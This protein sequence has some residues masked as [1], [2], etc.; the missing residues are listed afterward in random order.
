MR[1]RYIENEDK[2]YGAIDLSVIEISTRIPVMIDRAFDLYKTFSP[3]VLT[4]L[5]KKISDNGGRIL[6]RLQSQINENNNEGRKISTYSTY[7]LKQA[8]NKFSFLSITALVDNNIY[9]D[10]IKKINDFN[11]LNENFRA[12]SDYSPIDPEYNQTEGGELMQHSNYL[13]SLNDV[14]EKYDDYKL[15]RIVFGRIPTVRYSDYYSENSEYMKNGNLPTIGVYNKKN[16]VLLKT[17]FKPEI[18]FTL[19]D[20]FFKE[21]TINSSIDSNKKRIKNG[22]KYMIEDQNRSN[23]M[24]LDVETLF[25]GLINIIHEK[26]ISTRDCKEFSKDELKWFEENIL[27]GEKFISDDLALDKIVA[28]T[29]MGEVSRLLKIIF[30]KNFINIKENIPYAHIVDKLR[31][32]LE[33][34]LILYK[35]R[36]VASALTTYLANVTSRTMDFVNYSI[37]DIVN[38]YLAQTTYDRDILGSNADINNSSTL[39]NS[40]IRSRTLSFY[41]LMRNI[42]R[43]KPLGARNMLNED[44]IRNDSGGV[45]YSLDSNDLD[46]KELTPLS[47]VFYLFDKIYEHEGVTYNSQYNIISRNNTFT[48]TNTSKLAFNLYRA[49]KD[50]TA[51]SY[52]EMYKDLMGEKVLTGN[53]KYSLFCTNNSIYYLARNHRAL[54]SM[55]KS[56][57]ITYLSYLDAF[58]NE[59]IARELSDQGEYVKKFMIERVCDLSQI[60]INLISKIDYNFVKPMKD[61]LIQS[62]FFWRYFS[63]GKD[64]GNIILSLGLFH[65]GQVNLNNSFISDN[66]LFGKDALIN[67][68]IYGISGKYQFEPKYSL[69]F[70]DFSEKP[71]NEVINKY[72]L[73]DDNVLINQTPYTDFGQK[74]RPLDSGFD[75]FESYSYA[76]KLILKNKSRSLEELSKASE[77]L[78]NKVKKNEKTGYLDI[79]VLA[80]GCEAAILKIGE[81]SD[82][83]K[84]YLNNIDDNMKSILNIKMKNQSTESFDLSKEISDLLE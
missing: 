60:M 66:S 77:Y 35:N 83:D 46:S 48:F 8:I 45:F 38:N 32:R 4:K 31:E 52:F 3:T 30:D 75:G 12:S 51:R 80:F 69:T 22:G 49:I 25:L 29:D 76:E 74:D 17:L 73:K 57:L 79:A 54:S 44:Q 14:Y 47:F 33:D 63:N 71:L 43:I 9:D 27:N 53:P 16:R 40:N 61:N 28:R 58:K 84:E 13:S 7:D 36:I 26:V 41:N 15:N 65:D 55:Y 34:T 24:I 23:I 67:A 82:K 81:I 37:D 1:Y 72:H 39:Y 20:D 5:S 6:A 11:N 18:K 68:M 10:L 21:K 70:N 50:P 56:L 19:F 42:L 78:L 2:R 59:K 64:K 62:E